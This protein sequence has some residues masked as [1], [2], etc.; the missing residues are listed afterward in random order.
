MTI[1][2]EDSTFPDHTNY[3]KEAA[4]TGDDMPSFDMLYAELTDPQKVFVSEYLIDMNGTRASI[5]A[6]LSANFWSMALKKPAI[7]L[8][9]AA[10][11]HERALRCRVRSDEVLDELKILSFSDIT[12]YKFDS[13][14]RPIKEP[15]KEHIWRAV[16]SIKTRRKRTREGVE[17]HEV[18]IKLWSKPEAIRMAGQHLGMLRG[19]IDTNQERNNVVVVNIDMDKLAR[20]AHERKMIQSNQL[21]MPLP[22]PS[23]I[24]SPEQPIQDAEFTE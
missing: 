3:L 18:E 22:L 4:E 15:G 16:Q 7:R 5:R 23:P 6:G 19:D 13:M 10:G 14:G 11:I 2:T 8:A 21:E 24:E 20:E 17:T 1:T 9:I 12:D